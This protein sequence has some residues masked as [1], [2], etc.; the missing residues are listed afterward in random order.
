MRDLFTSDVKPGVSKWE[1][2]TPALCVDLDKME[3]NIQTMQAARSRRAACL[4]DR[5][6]RR[7]SARRDREI[8]VVHGLDR[9]LLRPKLGEAEAMI[10]QG[11]DKILMTTAN[12]SKNKIRRR[13]RFESLTLISSRQLTKSRTRAICRRRR[14]K[15]GS[16]RTS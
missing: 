15:P 9:D 5:T 2:D 3:K 14:R 8:S 12:P 11:I 16:P 1:L 4:A 7:T 6:P 10:A 13:W